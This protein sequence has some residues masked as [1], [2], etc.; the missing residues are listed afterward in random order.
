MIR[1]HRLYFGWVMLAALCV[2][3]PVSWGVLYDAFAVF[4][5]PM[6]ADLGWSSSQIT[7]AF[8][9]SLLITGFAGIP[10]GR[11]LDRRGARAVM[12]IG[13]ILAVLLVLAWSRADG[14]L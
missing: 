11:W 7:G 1:G 5:K 3:E 6:E 10:L 4:I 12:T 13:S 8:S 2:A 14:L 9:L